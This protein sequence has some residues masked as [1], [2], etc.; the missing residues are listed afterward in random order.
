MEYWQ[1][2][3][4]LEALDTFGVGAKNNKEFTLTNTTL[5]NVAV[6]VFNFAKVNRW[7]LSRN[8][9]SPDTILQEFQSGLGSLSVSGQQTITIKLTKKNDDILV[10][11][12]SR[13]RGG[14][15]SD[16]GAN[17]FNINQLEE[18]L[19]NPLGRLE[20]LKNPG[21]IKGLI[22]MFAVLFGGFAL[23]ILILNLLYRLKII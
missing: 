14:Q 22:S 7:S 6:L 19:K 11:I 23:I 16:W 17:E 15:I 21:E 13:S 8:E 10:N 18:Y 20:K 3:P 5:E 2:N 1:E 4:L 12:N 9:P